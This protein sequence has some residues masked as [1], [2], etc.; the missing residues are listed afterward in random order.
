MSRARQGRRRSHHVVESIEVSGGFLN[1]LKLDLTDGLNCV[2][3]GSGAGKTT[4]LT[5]VRYALDLMPAPKSDRAKQLGEVVEATLKHGRVRVAVRTKH[6][7][8]YVIERALHTP[9]QVFDEKGA[10]VTGSLEQADVFHADVYAKH[11]IDEIASETSK[12][13]ELLDRFEAPAIH[14]RAEELAQV[15]TALAENAVDLQRLTTRVRELESAT[16]SLASIELKLGELD[17]KE[18]PDAERINEAHR[19][20]E[21]RDKARSMF[22]LLAGSL[23]PLATEL[24]SAATSCARKLEARIDDSVLE[25]PDRKIVQKVVRPARELAASLDA[26]A[27]DIQKRTESLVRTIGQELEGLAAA[28]AKRE[29]DY[30][31]VL[32]LSKQAEERAVERR[33][34]HRRQN[35]LAVSK[36]EREERLQ[37][38]AKT[39]EKRSALV[40]R[41]MALRDE[42]FEL[43]RSVAERITGELGPRIRV[44]VIQAG[45]RTRYRDELRIA[46][47]GTSKEIRGLTTVIDALADNVMPHELAQLVEE[48]GFEALAR[49]A[50]IEEERARRVIELLAA[51]R[52]ALGTIETVEIEDVPRIELLDGEVPKPTRELSSGQRCIA[53]LPLLLLEGDHP[54][55]VDEP[56]GSLNNLYIYDAVVKTLA[57]VKSNRQLVLV[58]HNANILV[59]AETD[60]V[61]ELESNGREGRLAW[62]GVPE[63]RITRIEQVLEGGSI[64][65]L[66]R[67]KRYGHER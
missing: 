18:G 61:F 48:N 63:E 7:T 41:L 42:R 5:L 52:V 22:E 30:K 31:E 11:E 13:L 20:K 60:R 55:L 59:L 4:V 38:R 46:L 66:E 51:D 25:G 24:E 45:D 29:F 49:R 27:V 26:F 67:W 43:R 1:G 40:R 2:I 34:L 17:E 23:R 9:P 57:Q 54:I 12:Q 21:L 44:D 15:G 6:G 65:F 36:R 10:P 56:E 32:A 39:I 53:I 19:N 28:H 16:G 50:R 3:G 35:E 37:A 33:A 64:P 8:R 47:K 58:T 14:P 62:S